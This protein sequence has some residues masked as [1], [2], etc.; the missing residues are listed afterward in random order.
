[1]LR[2]ILNGPMVT[3]SEAE[4]SQVGMY[5]KPQDGCKDVIHVVLVLRRRS[6]FFMS[7]LA[8]KTS[9]SNAFVL[10]RTF[11]LVP[12]QSY[13][14]AAPAHSNSLSRVLSLSLQLPAS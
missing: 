7:G 8:L 4:L 13:F 10:N 1:M 12:A 6:V 14:L 2:K 9:E 5:C 11:R 3:V